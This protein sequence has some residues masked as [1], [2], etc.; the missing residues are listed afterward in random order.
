MSLVGQ[1][2]I[3]P[4]FIVVYPV[5]T[6]RAMRDSCSRSSFMTDRMAD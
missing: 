1:E 3:L 4:T 2:P 5:C 6:I